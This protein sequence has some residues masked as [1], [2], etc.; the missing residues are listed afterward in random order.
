MD[1]FLATSDIQVMQIL[2][3]FQHWIYNRVNFSKNL[4]RATLLMA[5]MLNNL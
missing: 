3:K 1:P 2:A 4:I 5:T